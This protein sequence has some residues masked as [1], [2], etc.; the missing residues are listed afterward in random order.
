[1]LDER[2]YGGLRVD[3]VAAKAGI[4]L[5]ALYRRW[6]T[7]AELVKAALISAAA[8]QH[9]AETG[10]A[11][12]DL[13][14]GLIALNTTLAGR[15]GRFLALLFA[16]TE[17]ELSAAIRETKIL[18]LRE[19]NR[20]RLRRVLSGAGEMDG[21][22]DRADAGVG[23]MVL[24]FMAQGTPMTTQ[25]IVDRVVPVMTGSAAA[26]G[27]GQPADPSASSPASKP[28]PYLE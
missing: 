9:V 5:G 20:Q 4:G 26:Y 24:H 1:L 17:P 3:D 8:Q 11:G 15:G 10:D 12:R 22:D 27:P 18:P 2:G 25:Q 14:D 21:V 7:K 13:L 16:G 23:L 28:D 19:A 6:S